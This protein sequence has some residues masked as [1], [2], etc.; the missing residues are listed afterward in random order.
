MPTEK[1]RSL[2]VSETKVDATKISTTDDL[3]LDFWP[4]SSEVSRVILRD[5]FGASK[6]TTGSNLAGKYTVRFNSCRVENQFAEREG[7]NGS[8]G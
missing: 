1:E 2:Q 7:E 4:R 6:T 8:A 3:S 5:C